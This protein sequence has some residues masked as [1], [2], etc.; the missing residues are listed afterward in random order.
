MQ[1][2]LE[3]VQFTDIK[4]NVGTFEKEISNQ[5]DTGLKFKTI[6]SDDDKAYALEFEIQLTNV[7]PM[8]SLYI[9]ATAHFSTTEVIDEEFKKSPFLDINSPAIVFPFIRAYIANLTLSSGYNPI[10]LPSYNFVK[11][12]EGKQ[13]KSK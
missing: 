8:F 3:T 10:V 11:I 7:E 2:K 9:K 13:K 5:L 6:F 4:Y 12:A 1:I